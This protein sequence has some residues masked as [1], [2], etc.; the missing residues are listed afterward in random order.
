MGF[1]LVLP[2]RIA[3]IILSS[4][5]FS[6]TLPPN[7]MRYVGEFRIAFKL[8]EAPTTNRPL[9]TPFPFPFQAEP[10]NNRYDLV[11]PSLAARLACSQGSPFPAKGSS[12]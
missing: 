6:V 10:G 5:P 9:R 8:P 3:L 7:L 12:L 2:S 11:P 1:G 4:F